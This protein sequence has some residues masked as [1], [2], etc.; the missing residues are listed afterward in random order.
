MHAS[1]ISFALLVSALLVSTTGCTEDVEHAGVDGT[2][3]SDGYALFSVDNERQQRNDV[4]ITVRD[5]DPGATYVLIYTSKAPPN[6]G[7]FQF[8]PASKSRC[9]GDVGDHC[10]IPGYGYLVDVV[11]V[12]EGARE[13]TLRDDQCG[14]DA[15]HYDKDWT[16]HWAVMR[17]ERPNKTSPIRVDVWAKAVKSH[18]EKPD[19]A[20]LQ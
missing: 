2:M 20:Q 15:D 1:K 3:K 6:V 13:I 8:D 11:T 9:G 17:I 10:A 14:C 7:W 4:S 18:A 5:V 16:G 12:P 19:L